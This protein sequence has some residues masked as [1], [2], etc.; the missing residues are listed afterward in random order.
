MKLLS[1]LITPLVLGLPLSEIPGGVAPEDVHWD[2][3]DFDGSDVDPYTGEIFHEADWS[4]ECDPWKVPEEAMANMET[5]YDT[6]YNGWVCPEEWRS[7]SGCGDFLDDPREM[8]CESRDDV[9]R[10]SDRRVISAAMPTYSQ[11]HSCVH[12]PLFYFNNYN[13]SPGAVVP[14]LIGR[15]RERWPKWGEYEFL[16]QQRWLHSAEHGAIVFLYN[17]C[18]SEESLCQL[19]QYISSKGEWMGSL[20]GQDDE[21]G[22]GEANR[23]RYILTP[24]KNLRKKFALMTYG[25]SLIS[26][27]LN[28]RDFDWFIEKYYRHSWEDWPPSGTYDYL[29]TGYMEH[30]EECPMEPGTEEIQMGDGKMCPDGY[31]KIRTEE[32]CEYAAGVLGYGMKKKDNPEDYMRGD[33]CM[34]SKKYGNGLLCKVTEGDRLVCRQGEEE[35]KFTPVGLGVCMSEDGETPPNYSKDGETMESCAMHCEYDEDCIGFSVQFGLRCALW[36]D[37]DWHDMEIE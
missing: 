13:T 11:F 19:R 16:P 37:M 21:V 3:V 2:H 25:E 36:M 7:M 18:I 23:F 5:A 26:S 12:H 31:S 1:L 9:P 30:D 14:P 35:E 29:W 20:Y 8:E 24:Y 15:H 28:E 32:D 6:E 22:R 17:S 27:C 10:C 33:V 34:I 4:P